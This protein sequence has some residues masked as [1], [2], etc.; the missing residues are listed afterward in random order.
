MHLNCPHCQNQIEV[1]EKSPPSEVVC[2]SCGS[3]IQLDPGRTETFLPTTG[4]RRLGKFEFLELLG[5]GAFGSVYKARDTQLDRLVAIKVPRAG[6]LATKVDI[7][8]FLREARSAAQLKHPSIVAVHDAGEVDGSC[9]LVSELVHGT[10]LADRL[11]SK[12]IA[13]RESAELITVVADALHYA[14][15]QGVIHRDMKPSNIMLD[16]DG[17]PHVMDFGL[18]KRDAGEITITLDGQILGT[19]AYMSPE[20]ARGDGHDVDPRCDVY[21]LGVILYELLTGELPF[22]GN[23]RMLIVQVLQ[24]EPR[25][26]R[27]LNDSIPRDLETITLKCLAKEP[28]RRYGTAGELAG[29]LR[30]FLQGEPILARPVGSAERAWRWVKR[31]PRVAILSGT[32]AL[33]L[34]TVATA[35]SILAVMA[36]QHRA[37]AEKAASTQ[38]ALRTTAE[39]SATQAE[40]NAAVARAQSQLALKSLESVILE[41][42]G[43]LK[44]VPGAGDL[45]R[46]L[47]Q[48]ALARLN[49]VSDQ[50]ASRAKIDRNTKVALD[51]LGDVFLRI[52]AGTPSGPDADGPL[53]AARKVYQQAFVIAQKLAAADPGNAGL[54]RDL[55]IS[56]DRLGKV[57]LQAGQVSQAL[58]YY[59]KGLEITQK[60]AD[61]DPKS[62]DAQRGLWV[63]YNQLGDLNLQAGHVADSLGHYQQGLKIGQRLAAADPMDTQAQR[64]LSISYSKLGDVSQLAGQFAE[65]LGHFQKMHGIN[66]QLAAASPMDAE[67][68]RDLAVSYWKLGDVNLDAS[69]VEVAQGHYQKGLEI[70]QKLAAAD[71]RDIRAKRDLS[72]SYERLGDAALQSGDVAK[73][74][75]YQKQGLEIRQKLAA[76]DPTDAQAKR[77]LSIS[78][79]KLGDV[80]LQAGQIAEALGHYQEG[81]E[82]AQT[83]AAANPT[84]AQAQ[85]G[86]YL[87]NAKLGDVNQSSNRFLEAIA[88]YQRAL[89][90]LLELDRS[91]RLAPSQRQYIGEIQRRLEQCRQGATAL[92]D[93]K[94]LLEQPADVLPVLLEI[95]GTHFVQIGRG[96]DAVQAVTKL[97]DLGTAT[98]DQLYNAACVYCLCAVHIKAEK[99][100]FTAEQ[101]VQRQKHIADALETLREA[102]QAGFKD[103]AQLQKDTDLSVLHDLP[104]FRA[105][106]PQEK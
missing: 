43:K 48:T 35:S 81:L 27:R 104:E 16:L 87:L 51:E 23:K 75:G 7:D 22:R 98:P 67:A 66:Q 6:N 12:R 106:I 53:A 89:D 44:N 13:F 14:H 90:V 46:A 91:N 52:G 80:S 99:D 101:T 84:D 93:W 20:Q 11:D 47:L 62:A 1:V 73:A 74:A 33:L 56:Y 65:A 55:S 9:Y 3:S 31:N 28:S 97:R 83:L 26:P 8:R 19:P 30:R 32:V 42:Q 40:E 64:D 41:I 5:I 2:P 78:Y 45:Q 94:S 63:S 36:E 105:L 49:E 15:S 17:Q 72:G 79:S 29:D 92:G 76:A 50:F 18:A 60:V 59:Q 77:D 57:S 37:F 21:S 103:F 70:S 39:A 82:V 85:F 10:T 102:L 71:P 24:D 34:V 96:S 95:R 100:E 38:R 25:P 86:L 69:Q 68:Q 54:Q 58:D 4:P 88:W 61:T